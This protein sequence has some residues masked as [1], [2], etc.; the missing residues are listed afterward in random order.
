MTCLGH[1]RQRGQP[2]GGGGYLN[3]LEG[4]GVCHYLG[5]PFF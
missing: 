4:T 5:V 1:F 2:R 3:M